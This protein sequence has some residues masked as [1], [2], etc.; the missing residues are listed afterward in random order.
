MIDDAK[1]LLEQLQPAREPL[2]PRVQ[3][4]ARAKIGARAGG[5]PARSE[6]ALVAAWWAATAPA[7]GALV[8]CGATANSCRTSL[9]RTGPN[10][11]IPCRQIRA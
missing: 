7:A 6:L 8:C 3:T 10:G 9:R 2:L 11:T 4:S 5:S 1:A